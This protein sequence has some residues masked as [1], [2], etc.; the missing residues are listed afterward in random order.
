MDG[1]LPFWVD[2]LM[3]RSEKPGPALVVSA[4]APAVTAHVLGRTGVLG[5]PELVAARGV[6]LSIVVVW[7]GQQHKM[8]NTI[9][10][11]NK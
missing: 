7:A 10:K 9:N 5:L 6:G 3:C 4:V 1:W 11:Y 8:I 2:G